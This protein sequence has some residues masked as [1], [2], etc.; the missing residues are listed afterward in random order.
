MN[1]SKEEA[2]QLFSKLEDHLTKDPDFSA[3]EIAE[4]KN[5]VNAWKGWV[6]MGRGA[7]WIITVLGLVAAA[8]ASWAVLA[9]TLKEWLR[10]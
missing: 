2:N 1:Y 4:L 6:A 10:S 3:S 9:N 8:I 7:K 5:M